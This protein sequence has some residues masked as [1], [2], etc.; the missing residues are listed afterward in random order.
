MLG[1]GGMGKTLGL[2]PRKIVECCKW[3]LMGHHGRSLEEEMLRAVWT[4]EAQLKRE[5]TTLATWIPA[6]LATFLANNVAAFCPC[7]KN[8]SEVNFWTEFCWQRRFEDGSHVNSVMC[9]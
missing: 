6:V 1:F 8:L 3:G 2:W 7:P 9:N 5:G 4:V